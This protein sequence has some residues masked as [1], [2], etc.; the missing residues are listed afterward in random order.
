MSILANG[1]ETADL[2]GA[3]GALAL[4]VS[5]LTQLTKNIGPLTKIPTDLQVLVTGPLL[6]VLALAAR[7]GEQG[8]RLPWYTW[9]G[10]VLAGLTAAFIAMYGWAA[11]YD[12]AER[13]RPGLSAAD[14]ETADEEDELWN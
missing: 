1:G 13:F 12:L 10:A 2:L 14:R 5:V 6:A 7:C 11:L 4:A 8:A 9:A 3:V